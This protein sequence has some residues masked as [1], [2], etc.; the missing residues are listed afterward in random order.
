M[1]EAYV[2]RGL[3]GTCGCCIVDIRPQKL[4]RT[5]LLV[6]L[7]GLAAIDPGGMCT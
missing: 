3:E 7:L 6:G 5:K 2:I 4:A 1:C